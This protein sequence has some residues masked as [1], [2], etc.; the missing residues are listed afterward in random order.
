MKKSPKWAIFAIM[1][2]LLKKLKG[3]EEEYI[4]KIEH[5]RKLFYECL[6]GCF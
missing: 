6:T 5:N 2:V 3:S 1:E 4:E